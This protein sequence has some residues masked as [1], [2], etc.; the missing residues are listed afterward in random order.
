MTNLLFLCATIY[1]II[2][3]PSA[4]KTSI[5]KEL[6][7]NG[8]V[9]IEES[10]TKI[11]KRNLDQNIKEPWLKD[12]FQLE[13]FTAKLLLETEMLK[14][15]KK[16]IFIDRGLLDNLVYLEIA[17][18]ENSSE[19]KEIQKKLKELN[20]ENRYA[21]VFFIEPHGGK[22]FELEKN[23]IRRENTQEALLLS[24]KIKAAYGKYYNLITIPGGMSP[25]KRAAFIQ[26]KIQSLKKSA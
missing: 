9:I 7:A 10:A 18:K 8:Q 24:K 19:Y 16:P 25:G 6:Q 17:G 22:D 20:I 4:G 5:I 12:G 1:A 15:C 26:Q 11:I 21:A 23:E 14:S 13:I 3:G 2:G